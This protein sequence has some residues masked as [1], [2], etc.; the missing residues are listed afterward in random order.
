M[1]SIPYAYSQNYFGEDEIISVASLLSTAEEHTIIKSSI[2]GKGKLVFIGHA[3]QQLFTK[4]LV[5]LPEIQIQT[6]TSFT[7]ATPVIVRGNVTVHTST[8]F[9][10]AD[11]YLE[12]KLL[13]DP[14]TVLYGLGLIIENTSTYQHTPTPL[15]SSVSYIIKVVATSYNMPILPN[16]DFTYLNNNFSYQAQYPSKVFLSL[17]TPP[18]KYIG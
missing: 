2:H 7:F 18:P 14:Q 13:K 11:V 16:K 5:S 8:L 12:G 15:H 3:D 1:V 6:T 10:E 9:V 17:P 4:D